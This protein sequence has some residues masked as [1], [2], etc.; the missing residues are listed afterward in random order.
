LA[1]LE[2]R[3]LIWIAESLPAWV[4]SDHLTLLGFVSLAVT[5]LLYWLARANRA[6]L[7]AAVI[8]LSLNW[9]G[10]SL[11]GT[12]ARVRNRQRPRY[13]F[14]GTRPN[15]GVLL[16]QGILGRMVPSS[17]RFEGRAGPV[18]ASEELAQNGVRR[19][20]VADPPGGARRTLCAFTWTTS[21]TH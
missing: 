9:F 17:W 1:T 13:G 21:W 16:V 8:F 14:R 18:R 7:A 3:T 5:G 20:T 2:K 10:D 11:D 4:N 19:E 12:L 15:D 6:A